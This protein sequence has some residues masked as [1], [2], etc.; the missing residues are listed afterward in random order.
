MKVRFVLRAAAGAVLLTAALFHP[1]AITANDALPV[2]LGQGSV[3][4]I[5]GTSTVHE[6]ECTSKAVQISLTR[7]PDAAAPADVAG[8]AALIRGSKVSGV[9]VRVPVASL[10]SGKE[11][12][13]KNLRKAMKADKHPDVVF[14]LSRYTLGPSTED[15]LGIKAEGTLT[16]A[17]TARPITLEGR[18]VRG[19]TGI[20]LTGQYG[21]R[22]SEFGI[23][24]PTMMLGALRVADPVTVRYRLQL[25]PKGEAPSSSQTSH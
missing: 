19:G 21:L 12:L 10:K 1:A 9:E 2:E 22:M 16:V 11:A 17:G 5:H 14:V 24:P 8:L 6:Y 7:A 15:S 23:K 13:D 3:L 18:A 4:S 20:W 25:I